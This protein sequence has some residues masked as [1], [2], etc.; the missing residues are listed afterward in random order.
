MGSNKKLISAFIVSL[1]VICKCQT[2]S[3]EKFNRLEK[4]LE[5]YWESYYAFPDDYQSCV[6]AKENG[7]N[8]PS[9]DDPFEWARNL[10]ELVQRLN[11]KSGTIINIAFASLNI[12]RRVSIKKLYLANLYFQFRCI[13]QMQ[14]EA[15]LPRIRLRFEIIPR[16]ARGSMGEIQIRH[17]A[18]EGRIRFARQTGFRG[19]KGRKRRYSD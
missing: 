2:T 3:R 6:S 10:T 9:N 15:F 5:V 11:P 8:P 17:S 16:F 12:E 14:K 4:V 19:G 13:L 18:F 1:V 7:I